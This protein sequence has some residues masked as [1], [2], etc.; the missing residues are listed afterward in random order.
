MEIS[1][2]GVTSGPRL[3]ARVAPSH[4]QPDTDDSG[5]DE[6]ARQAHQQLEHLAAEPFQAPLSEP[7]AAVVLHYAHSDAGAASAVAELEALG[8]R[9]C[10]VQADLASVEAVRQLATRALDFLGG[11]DA[12]VNNAG[13]TMNRPFAEITPEQFDRLYHVNVRAGFFL[14]QSLYP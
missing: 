1:E 10:A 2:G 6:Q 3:A 9:A 8:V 14:T 4:P 13:I 5:H 12:L 11:L 7:G